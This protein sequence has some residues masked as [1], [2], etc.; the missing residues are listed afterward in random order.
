MKNFLK[1]T[2][3][4]CLL[5][6]IN[7]CSK[8][9]SVND[10]SNEVVNDPKYGISQDASNSLIFRTYTTEGDVSFYGTK[11]SDGTVISV[12]YVMVKV[13]EFD[14][15]ILIDLLENG[16]IESIS[17]PNGE[18]IGIEWLNETEIKLL[19]I[20]ENGN[21]VY[22]QTNL[23]SPL[24]EGDEITFLSKGVKTKSKKNN[25][26][27]SNIKPGANLK[28]RLRMDGQPFDDANVIVEARGVDNK[29]DLMNYSYKAKPQSIE[30]G[31]FSF[32]ISEPVAEEI[33]FNKV[34]S[35]AEDVLGT[36]CSG[37]EPLMA[38]GAVAGTTYL[39]SQVGVAFNVAGLP[40]YGTCEVL[41]KSLLLYCSTLGA[42]PAPG[43]PSIASKICQLINTPILPSKYKLSVGIY[44]NVGGIYVL[45]ADQDQNVSGPFG[46][47]IFEIPENELFKI[48]AG[49]YNGYWSGNIISQSYLSNNIVTQ[50]WFIWLSILE[51]GEV[52]YNFNEWTVAP[53][54]GAG[55]ISKGSKLSGTIKTIYSTNEFGEFV[56]DDTSS[57]INTGGAYTL[58]LDGIETYLGPPISAFVR[59]TI[60]KSY[61]MSKSK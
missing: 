6:I 59:T 18:Y 9:E 11:D 33:D 51:N 42:S 61:I 31:V 46:D 60:D 55:A 21:Q 15:P 3:I 40:A 41:T 39:C 10:E 56:I 2:L 26:L 35:K 25:S 30:N 1:S 50:E 54:W 17:S 49:Q 22:F 20:S 8:N 43:A 23:N 34:C 53:F 32:Y 13:E 14:D 57:I 16:R 19:A 44:I 12:D 5:I 24:E 27:K 52:L 36:L 37:I 47:M 28:V 48:Y 38:S 4:I 29:G 58:G 45:N 7:S